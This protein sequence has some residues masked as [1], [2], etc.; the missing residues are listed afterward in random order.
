RTA[1]DQRRRPSMWTVV[2]IIDE[3]PL[4]QEAFHFLRCES[5]A[6]LDRR[7]ARYHMQDFVEYITPGRLFPPLGELFGHVANELIEVGTGQHR[8]I[9][10]QNDRIS[11]EFVDRQPQFRKQFAMFDQKRR[12]GRIELD[13]L[14][15]EHALRLNSSLENT[16][17]KLLVN[18]PFMQCMLI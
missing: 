6:R 10:G 13:R 8:R 9:S 1:E 5:L 12:L 18:D 3:M 17:P 7:L 14:R 2:S 16:P 15:N 4:L 11:A